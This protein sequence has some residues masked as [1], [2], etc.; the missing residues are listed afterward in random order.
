MDEAKLQGDE[1][2]LLV[3]DDDG[4]RA[5]TESTLKKYGYNV[6]SAP[7]GEEA[8]CV[9]D[10]YNSKID[11]LLTDVI[12]P[13]MGGREL[14]EK[15]VEKHN[16]LKVLFFSGYTD[17]SIVRHGIISEGMEFIQ[18]PYSQTELARKI[19]SIFSQ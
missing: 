7:N 1:T 5:V 14:A 11:L 18:K 12:M 10:E 9:Y 8:I 6:I 16:N 15:L 17:D 13:V 19:K 3:E 4:V 2:I